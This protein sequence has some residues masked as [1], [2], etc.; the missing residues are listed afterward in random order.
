VVGT[1]VVSSNGGGGSGGGS[2][3]MSD[4]ENLNSTSSNS[5]SRKETNKSEF[6]ASHHIRPYNSNSLDLNTSQKQKQSHLTET[7]SSTTNRQQQKKQP[8]ESNPIVPST[9]TSALPNDKPPTATTTTTTTTKTKAHQI[10]TSHSYVTTMTSHQP[11]SPTAYIKSNPPPTSTATGVT[12]STSSTTLLPSEL[13]SKTPMVAAAKI[14]TGTSSASSS[15][16]SNLNYHFGNTSSHLGNHNMGGQSLLLN[17][18]NSLNKTNEYAR[19]PHG[20]YTRVNVLPTNQIVNNNTNTNNNNSNNNNNNSNVNQVFNQRSPTTFRLIRS[21]VFNHNTTSPV[22]VVAQS[23]STSVMIGSSASS[24]SS[25]S[26]RD[27]NSSPVVQHSQPTTTTSPHIYNKDTNSISGIIGMPSTKR[28]SSL[29]SI[30]KQNK[31]NQFDLING[32]STSSPNGHHHHH[33][34]HHQQHTAA[35]VSASSFI[36]SNTPTKQQ[37]QNHSMRIASIQQNQHQKHQPN[38]SNM[39]IISQKPTN[40]NNGMNANKYNQD[41]IYQLNQQINTLELNNNKNRHQNVSNQ[42]AFVFASSSNALATTTNSSAKLSQKNKAGG[43]SII[44]Q[45][46]YI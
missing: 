31:H 28:T 35:S 41:R 4:Y 44:E 18:K 36:Q 3:M 22:R 5:M 20:I 21:P 6:L 12:S 15:I 7:T 30:Q 1:A 23:T 45:F 11:K 27:V 34:H 13:T 24:S 39:N 9:S 33:N 2:E 32:H 38:Y 14:K 43:S 42:T 16:R 29:K 17:V 37:L 25:S 19:S 10:P 26:N 46:D 8:L 40:A